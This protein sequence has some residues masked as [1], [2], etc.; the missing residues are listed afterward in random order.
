LNADAIADLLNLHIAEGGS[1]LDPH[2]LRGDVPIELLGGLAWPITRAGKLR[3]LLLE[4]GASS[5]ETWDNF[6]AD[7]RSWASANDARLEPET[8][9]EGDD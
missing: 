7:L 8:E 5:N 1:R 9:L 6:L 3:G 4:Q 2:S